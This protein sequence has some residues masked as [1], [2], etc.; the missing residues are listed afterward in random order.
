MSQNSLP[1]SNSQPI[2]DAQIQGLSYLHSSIQIVV[3]P[4][5]ESLD[6]TSP[7]PKF[8]H[9]LNFI[10]IPQLYLYFDRPSHCHT[11]L[12]PAYLDWI[13]RKMLIMYEHNEKSKLQKYSCYSIIFKC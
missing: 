5:C 3:P 12:A 7:T 2:G 1:C 11:I 8:P 13:P 4:L 6:K 9:P 10:P